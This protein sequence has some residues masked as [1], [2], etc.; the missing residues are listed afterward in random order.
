MVNLGQFFPKQ[1]FAWF[2]TL[3]FFSRKTIVTSPTYEWI[4]NSE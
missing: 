4:K 1:I 2:A 3:I